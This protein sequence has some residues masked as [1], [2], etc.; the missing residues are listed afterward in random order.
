MYCQLQ[1]EHEIENICYQNVV[2]RF[3]RFSIRKF[4]A[5]TSCCH[6]ETNLGKKQ[7]P[8][9]FHPAFGWMER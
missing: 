4:F 6:M 9:R 5:H 2:V 7:I 8:L 1:T 3:H